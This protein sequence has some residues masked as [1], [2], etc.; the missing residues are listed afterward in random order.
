MTPE[1]E[2][3]L[4]RFR[5]LQADEIHR[6]IVEQN[7][8]FIS[9]TKFRAI[10][11]RASVKAYEKLH[12]EFPDHVA[13]SSKKV[14]SKIQELAELALKQ[15]KELQDYVSGLEKDPYPEFR[16]GYCAYKT[17]HETAGENGFCKF[18]SADS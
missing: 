13:E 3:V 12:S 11:I 10:H 9:K 5:E 15:I 8:H 18:H 17:C 4:H 1:T 14:P 2:K 6:E 16:G 7:K